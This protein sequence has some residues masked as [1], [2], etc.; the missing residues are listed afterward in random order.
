MHI[1]GE[2]VSVERCFIGFYWRQ[3]VGGRWRESGKFSGTRFSQMS[4]NIGLDPLMLT[5]VRIHRLIFL[6]RSPHP[7]RM[8]RNLSSLSRDEKVTT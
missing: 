5:F 1:I 7:T 6:H 3:K 4:E 2:G 8:T